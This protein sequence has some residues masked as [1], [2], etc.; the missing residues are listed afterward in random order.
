MTGRKFIG[1]IVHKL[2]MYG[3]FGDP[4]M[5]GYLRVVALDLDSA[6]IPWVC[7]ATPW[8]VVVP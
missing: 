5:T 2:T 6:D 8:A 1:S 4:N 7:A 3:T